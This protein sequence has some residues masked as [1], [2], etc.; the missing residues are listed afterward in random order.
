MNYDLTHRDGKPYV[1]IPLHE[2][3][4]M[5][6]DGNFT[7]ETSTATPLPKEVTD[8]LETSTDH[9]IKIIRKHKGLTQQELASKANIS[10]PFLTE[11]E[12]KKKNGSI[13]A[14]KQI[15]DALDVSIDQ[16]L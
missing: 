1:M 7:G 13:Q 11:I 2:Y 3:R 16:L 6:K 8:A 14:L 9:P 10:R 5:T 12:T 4:T 15:A